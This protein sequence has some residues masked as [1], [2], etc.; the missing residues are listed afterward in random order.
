[1]YWR[2]DP[3]AEPEAA[4]AVVKRSRTWLAADP[5][6]PPSRLMRLLGSSN[7]KD[8]TAK[9][10]EIVYFAPRVSV[11]LAA[12][13]AALDQLGVPQLA[14]PARRP[15]PVQVKA[16][17]PRTEPQFVSG[18]LGE[19]INTLLAGLPSWVCGLIERGHV[20]GDSYP[21]RSEADAAVVRALV[22]AGADD[23]EIAT[24]FA[25]TEI[26]AKYS[27]A[28]DGY[29]A[30][31]I[32]FV[33]DSLLDESQVLVEAV[34][35]GP[36]GGRA[37]LRLRVVDGANAGETFA[38]GVNSR[39]SAWPWLFRAAD[40]APPAEGATDQTLLLRGRLLRVRIERTVWDGKPR[41][42]VA[43]FLPQLQHRKEA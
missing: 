19:G 32:D 28:G 43:R 39:S 4:R 3:V 42:Q 5:T 27:E 9:R 7:W 29:L 6:E 2:I 25:S 24:I 1:M 23:N 40:I 33:R 26:G 37:V 21:S 31:T 30:R 14:P 13:S 17:A 8:G 18:N 35:P 34:T 20:E 41:L 11:S 16:A 12:L 36:P 15:R 10:I 22:D 38:H